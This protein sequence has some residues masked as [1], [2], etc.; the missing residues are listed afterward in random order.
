MRDDRQDPELSERREPV[1]TYSRVVKPRSQDGGGLD[2]AGPRLLGIEIPTIE[3]VGSDEGADPKPDLRADGCEGIDL[4]DPPRRFGRA[5]LMIGL[6]AIV[7]GAGILYRSLDEATHIDVA[8]PARTAENQAADGEKAAGTTAATA[9]PVVGSAQ[10]VRQVGTNISENG[11]TQ[12]ATDTD[13]K[14]RATAAAK[15]GPAAGARTDVAPP[16]A[17]D[18]PGTRPTEAATAPAVAPEPR[19]RPE[20]KVTTEAAVETP[21]AAVKPQQPA[22]VRPERDAGED[23]FLSEIEQA[24]ASAPAD[25][26]DGSPAM[27]AGEPT[28][29]A[30]P[31]PA[32]LA[33]AGP[34]TSGRPPGLLPPAD[35]PDSQDYASDQGIAG[36]PM[37]G[38]DAM[39]RPDAAES[40][41]FR[42]L[43]HWVVV[44]VQDGRAI[45]DGRGRGVFMV[46]PGSILPGAGTVEAIEWHG[47]R[48][49]VLT[50]RGPIVSVAENGERPL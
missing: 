19:R 48:W 34:A 37:D 42:P 43:R 6:V 20:R 49:V 36:P 3:A 11:S 33:E 22:P 46:E 50:T 1:V 41:D 15:N 5:W 31:P 24:L 18:D 2:H 23:G 10:A 4:D 8:A 9:E 26:D 39:D 35:I 30:P 27:A 29:G 21:P 32:P 45:V 17:A 16:I 25:A 12:P 40:A 38:P 44:G 28:P 14:Q 47:D 13:S 7:A